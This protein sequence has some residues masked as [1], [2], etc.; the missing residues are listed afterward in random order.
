MPTPSSRSD[1]WLARAKSVSGTPCSI[2]AEIGKVSPEPSTS[3]ARTFG[4]AVHEEAFRLIN[5]A[6]DSG[7]A[8]AQNLA[9]NSG[10]A[11]PLRGLTAN[12][13]GLRPDIRLSLG[14][15]REAVWD[16]TTI[17]QVRP[18]FGH[19]GT[20]YRSF[21]FVDYIADLPYIR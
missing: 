20:N 7:Q 15:G 21:A 10:A 4:N 19:A 1:P 5:A 14:G 17:A 8:W 9:T 6:R 13:G 11:F 16:I 18:R 12:F 2:V 3:Y